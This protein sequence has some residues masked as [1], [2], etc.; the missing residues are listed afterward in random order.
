MCDT[1]S[2]SSRGQTSALKKGRGGGERKTSSRVHRPRHRIVILI[3][4]SYHDCA[5]LV[6]LNSAAVYA[7][8]H[9]IRV[10]IEPLMIGGSWGSIFCGHAWGVRVVGDADTVMPVIAI[11]LD[12][13]SSCVCLQQQCSAN[14]RGWMKG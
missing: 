11:R 7:R 9:T 12:H 14:T 4:L 2:M 8:A 13:I 3:L 5:V 1:Q 6:A 10:R